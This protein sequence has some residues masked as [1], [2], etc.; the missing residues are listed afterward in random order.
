MAT[1]K[2]HWTSPGGVEIVLPHM[3]NIPAGILRKNRN[4]DELN[5]MFAVIEDQSDE[6]MLE[7]VDSLTLGDLETLVEAW[8]SE[9]S[10][11][12]SLRSS[13]S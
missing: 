1:E 10:P 7:K 2:F 13:T 4:S 6:A 3:R 5:I 8:T 12:E 11:G 9:V